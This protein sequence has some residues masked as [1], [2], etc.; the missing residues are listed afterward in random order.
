MRCDEI[1]ELIGH[2][3][4]GD[5][6][7]ETMKRLDRHLLRCPA[8]AYEARAMEQTRTLLQD[9]IPPAELSPAFREKAA[10]RLLDALAP[11]LRSE[12]ETETARQWRLPF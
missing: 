6:P 1:Q 8:C 12:P 7:E 5:L 3:V 11:H 2:Y 4:D 9:A 10:A